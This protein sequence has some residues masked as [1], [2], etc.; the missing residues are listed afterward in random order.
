MPLGEA[1]SKADVAFRQLL[2]ALDAEIAE[3]N[4]L[5][6]HTFHDISPVQARGLLQRAHNRAVLRACLSKLHAQWETDTPIAVH[7]P[8]VEPPPPPM[9]PEIARRVKGLSLAR[10]AEKLMVGETTIKAWLEEGKLKGFRLTR[11]RWRIPEHELIRFAL[12]NRDLI[13]A[14]LMDPAA[15]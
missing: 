7:A 5:G 10:A 1:T 11:G 14:N 9:T 2:A 3:L 8:P 13:S 12:N 15:R 6:S 4:R